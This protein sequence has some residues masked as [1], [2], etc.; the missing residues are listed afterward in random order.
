MEEEIPFPAGIRIRNAPEPRGDDT[1]RKP[2][3][4][5][6]IS[7]DARRERL[8]HPLGGI[9]FEEER[10]VHRAHDQRESRVGHVVADPAELCAGQ[11]HL[12]A[13]TP[14]LFSSHRRRVRRCGRRVSRFR[15]CG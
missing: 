3:P 8:I 11:V 7:P 10:S 6:D 13:V 12:V 1:S 15:G 5:A 4:G 2:S 14:F 9:P